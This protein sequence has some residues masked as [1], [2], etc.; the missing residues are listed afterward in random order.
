MKKTYF[1][2]FIRWFFEHKKGYTFLILSFVFA[3]IGF[4]FFYSKICA[5]RAYY[6]GLLSQK[7]KR[8][9]LQKKGRIVEIITD[10]GIKILEF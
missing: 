6:E 8:E 2:S 5:E 1:Y 4:I 10:K 9:P 3:L 7:N